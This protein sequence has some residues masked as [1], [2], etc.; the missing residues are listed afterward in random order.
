MTPDWAALRRL[1]RPCAIGI[2]IWMAFLAVWQ[3]LIPEGK[4]RGESAASALPLGLLIAAMAVLVPTSLVL[5]FAASR[6]LWRAR[7]RLFA[8]LPI[9]LLCGGVWALP[10]L[11]DDAGLD[12]IVS[13]WM[14]PCALLLSSL[15]SAAFIV[16]SASP[17]EPPSDP[18]MD[19][20][21]KA[22]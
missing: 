9:P 17:P 20:W 5:A 18:G 7:R 1:L 2:V 21:S 22:A 8:L 10:T 6:R 15:A 14:V 19:G 13:I 3:F 12:R 4:S 11:T 16:F